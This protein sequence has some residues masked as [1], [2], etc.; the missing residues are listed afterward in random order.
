MQ[1]PI[2]RNIN[3]KYEVGKKIKARREELGLSQDQLADRLGTNRND[4]SK[5][6]TGKYEMGISALFQYA[7][8]LETDP[9]QLSPQRFNRGQTADKAQQL[10]AIT[11][12]TW[13]R[14]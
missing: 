10:A 12:R 14:S 3:D 5:Y 2:E 8:A 9:L 13:I 11:S 6:E 1:M 7:E 4:V